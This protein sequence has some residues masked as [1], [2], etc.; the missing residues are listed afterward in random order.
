MVDMQK[1]TPPKRSAPRRIIPR[2]QQSVFVQ[3]FATDAKRHAEATAIEIEKRM[4]WAAKTMREIRSRYCMSLPEGAMT[5]FFSDLIALDEEDP[6]RICDADL[7]E[8]VECLE[9]LME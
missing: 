2:Q 5:F 1:Q 8:I 3:R 7:Q 6:E 9:G 4:A